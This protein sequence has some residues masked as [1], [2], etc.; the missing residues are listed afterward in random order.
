MY[1]QMSGNGKLVDLIGLCSW[2][3]CMITNM[4]ACTHVHTNINIFNTRWCNGWQPLENNELCH[5]WN[6]FELWV[7]LNIHG[8]HMYVCM[9][10][11]MENWWKGTRRQTKDSHSKS[12]QCKQRSHVC[13]YLCMYQWM[14]AWNVPVISPE[15]TTPLTRARHHLMCN[16]PMR[17]HEN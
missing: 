15:V 6:W 13:M 3:C 10:Y 2:S 14:D 17:T 5:W 11:S 16:A 12:Q 8:G 9:Y 1:K 7:C 4:H